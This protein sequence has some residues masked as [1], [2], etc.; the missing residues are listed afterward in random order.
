MDKCRTTG[1]K[2]PETF[3]RDECIHDYCTPGFTPGLS[4]TKK[5]FAMRIYLHTNYLVFAV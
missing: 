3:F 2:L 4:D 5:A 1:R